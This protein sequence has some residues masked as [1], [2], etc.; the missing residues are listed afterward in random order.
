MA[1]E[2]HLAI[3]K[4]GVE[5]WNKWRKANPHIVPDLSGNSFIGTQ[6]IRIDFSRANLTEADFSH[7]NLTYSNLNK[8]NLTKANFSHTALNNSELNDAIFC[9][10]L[11]IGIEFI[12]SKLT[13]ANFA[14]SNLTDAEFYHADAEQSIFINADLT[15]ADLSMSNLKGANLNHTNLVRTR[16]FDA[17]FVEADFT[18]ACL[19]GCSLYTAKDLDQA[20][21]L[22]FFREANRSERQPAERD[23]DFDEFAK[24]CKEEQNRQKKHYTPISVRLSS[25]KSSDE[26]LKAIAKLISTAKIEAIFDPYFD[27]A[28]L[29]NLLKLYN[30]EVFIYSYIRVL[31][32]TKV[33]NPKKP[34]LTRYKIE[35]FFQKFGGSGEFRCLRSDKEHRRFILL[36]NDT[37]LII[38]CSLNDI[39]KNEVAHIESDKEDRI[40]FDFEWRNARQI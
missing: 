23:F 6:F 39:S 22:Y 32:S 36:N 16:V 28:A 24:L 34:R 33:L 21:C 2:E 40:F 35:E 27:D 20:K 13:G 38:G 5:I 8:A 7:A 14:Y 18:G 4:Q 29:S 3:L 19:E 31:T 1:D 37:S 25:S 26:N 15:D 17:N 9:D 30:S 12:A 10:A 11:L